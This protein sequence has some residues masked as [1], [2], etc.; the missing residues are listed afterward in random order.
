MRLATMDRRPSQPEKR[1]PR[2][3]LLALGTSLA[4]WAFL[5]L[6]LLGFILK[7]L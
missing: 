1:D 5:L 7:V 4:M 6:G 3:L 2:G